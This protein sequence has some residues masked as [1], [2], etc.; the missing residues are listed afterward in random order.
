MKNKPFPNLDGREE[1]TRQLRKAAIDILG[2]EEE[3]DS[4][5]YVS[6]SLACRA[7]MLDWAID[8]NELTV[9]ELSQAN[10]SYLG[11]CKK[12]KEGLGDK[13]LPIEKVNKYEFLDAVESGVKSAIWELATDAT[14]MP[15]AD[16]YESIKSGAESAIKGIKDD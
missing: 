6:R 15:C 1:K 13:P 11:L 16:F 9:S 4:A 2:G 8:N 14:D 10:N 7:A 3:Y 5:S 12:I